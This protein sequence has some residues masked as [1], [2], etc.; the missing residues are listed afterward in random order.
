M[1]VCGERAGHGGSDGA[2]GRTSELTLI[3]CSG[4]R[5]GDFNQDWG[6]PIKIGRGYQRGVLRLHFRGM[7]TISSCMLHTVMGR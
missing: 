5:V 6:G 4:K 3:D 1:C 7:F 2:A